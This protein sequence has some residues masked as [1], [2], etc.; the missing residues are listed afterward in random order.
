MYTIRYFLLSTLL[1]LVF[2]HFIVA[3]VAINVDGNEPDSS[4]MLDI[5]S[6]DKGLLT[7]R[8]TTAQREMISS[9]ATGLL[10]FDTT[11]ESFWV[12]ATEWQEITADNLGDHKATENIQLQGYF[13]SN[14]GE[15]EGIMINDEGRVGINIT[16]EDHL[17]VALDLTE[18][19]TAEHITPT[20]Q[21]YVGTLPSWQSFTASS[22]GVLSKVRIQYDGQIDGSGSRVLSIYQSEGT[23]G[24]LLG[25]TTV[26]VVNQPDQR[27]DVV[28]EFTDSEIII[29]AHQVYTFHLDSRVGVGFTQGNQ[30]PDGLNF[31]GDG[32]RDLN[33][34]VSALNR[35]TFTVGDSGVVVNN[36]RLPYSDG[37]PNQVLITDGAGNTSWSSEITRTIVDDDHDTKVMAENQPNEDAIRFEVDSTEVLVIHEQLTQLNTD[38]FIGLNGFAGASIRSIN[39][40]AVGI[41]SSFG[42]A[43]PAWQSFTAEEDGKLDFIQLKYAES[44]D[45]IYNFVLYQ[46]EGESGQ[47]IGTATLNYPNE[48]TWNNIDFSTQDITLEQG[49]KYTLW[50]DSKLKWT[51]DNGDLYAGG[52]SSF[53][54]LFDNELRVYLFPIEPAFAVRSGTVT[55]NAFVGDGAGLTNV[56]GDDLGTHEANQNLRLSG[57]WLSNDG[58]NEGINID[59]SGNVGIGTNQPSAK[60]DIDGEL[61]LSG[62][63][64]DMGLVT[65]L[66]TSAPIMN[67]ALNAFTPSVDASRLGGMFRIDSRNQSDDPLFQWIEK[68]VGSST[69]TANDLLMTLDRSGLQVNGTISASK[70]TGAGNNG[71][72]IDNAG[73]VGIGTDQPDAK[74]DIDGELLLSGSILDMGLIT[75]L[76]T[77]NPIM[78]MA[79]NVLTPSVD[80]SRLGGVFRIDSRDQNNDPLFQWIEKPVGI[81]TPTLS[82]LLMTLDDSGLKVNR[83]VNI[84]STLG[85][86]GHITAQ[87]YLAIN[88]NGLNLTLASDEPN[89]RII[90]DAGGSGHSNAAIV[91]GEVGTGSANPVL[92]KGNLGVGTFSAPQKLS[93]GVQGDG[94]RGIA[95]DWDTWSDQRL[96]R[97][98]VELSDPLEKLQAI[99]G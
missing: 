83:P 75:E 95:N 8:M 45:T 41:F 13:L 31:G 82:D 11:T 7:P 61:I 46:G 76:E 15:D 17:T 39:I 71:I 90:L 30:Y 98:F 4:A 62:S 85:V 36:Y 34:T 16:P 43:G 1:I 97:D 38:F 77:T 64:L 91:L 18:I 14:D 44:P 9:P 24:M 19:T 37:T 53:D 26:E 96:K 92:M 58:G 69:S 79:L 68:P 55:A 35:N 59:N 65:E 50:A 57:N 74:L 42:S 6:A 67:M 54:P 80:I 88:N 2:S 10:V 56:P 72:S 87:N 78:N 70:Y 32:D 81:G 94:T 22:D 28:F 73:N 20:T 33:F 3:Q 86:G 23:E 93:V 99:N 29:L 12:Y 60:L 25:S 27:Y 89:N 21:I 40:Q 48:N 49:Q 5:S 47:P 51:L 63:I 52:R 66:E 84:T